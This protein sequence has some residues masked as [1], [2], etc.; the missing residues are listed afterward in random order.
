MQDLGHNSELSAPHG[1]GI[2]LAEANSGYPLKGADFQRMA[3][4]RFQSPTPFR[5]GNWWWIRVWQDQFSDGRLK[6]KQKRIKL[7]P[8]TIG[9]REARKIATEKLR[10]LNQGLEVIGSA[11]QFGAYVDGIYRGTVLPLLAS[12]TRTVYSWVLDKYLVPMFGDAMLRDLNTMTLQKY[13]SGL[14]KNHATAVKVKDALASVLGSALRFELLA[15]NPLIGV[16]IPSP[17]VGKRTKPHITPEH[18][19]ALVGLVAEP[20]ATM[21]YTCVMAGLR[22][23]ELVGLKWEDIHADS[24]TIDERFSRGEWGCPKTSASN[25]T[26]GVDERIIQRINR[27]KD[28][29]VT[30]N[31]GAR[32]AKRTF[33]LVLSD[34]PGDLVFQSLIKRGPMSDHNVLSRHIKPAARRLGLG[35]VNWQVLRRSYATWLIE[36][37]AD[38][39]AVQAQMRHSRSSTTMDI[40]AQF[41]PAAQRRAVSQMMDMVTARLA[42]ATSPSEMVN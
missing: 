35:W 26:I 32:G 30:I 12:T 3:K 10:P 8:A 15:K 40:Y 16:Q 41:V 7:A 4:R 24:L 28:M 18:F 36:A 6:R 37:G 1:R 2:V 23:S 11:T 9:E 21:I 27:L 5:E 34:A 14:G 17:R 20:Y 22:V 39:K 33:K 25:A 42:K 31:W 13:F 29:E 19:D 38:P